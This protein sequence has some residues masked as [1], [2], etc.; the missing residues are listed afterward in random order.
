MDARSGQNSPCP[1]E[2]L[3]SPA[4]PFGGRGQRGQIVIT[5]II[6]PPKAFAFQ[7]QWFLSTYV[8][9]EWSRGLSSFGFHFSSSIGNP[10][11]FRGAACTGWALPQCAERCHAEGV[12]ILPDKPHAAFWEGIWRAKRQLCLTG[13][14]AGIP[15]LSSFT[16]VTRKISSYGIQSNNM[17]VST[18][19]NV[20]PTTVF[21]GLQVADRVVVQAG[22]F[23]G[24]TMGCRKG[25]GKKTLKKE[26]ATLWLESRYSSAV[27]QTP[28][29]TGKALAL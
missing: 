22:R 21:Q 27:P 8:L 16:G 28:T 3:Q 10:P 20:S 5:L 1:W 23:L 24:L 25:K 12:K 29:D 11:W 9:K 14:T 15:Q 13:V 2:L 6:R 17:C 26:K 4:E 18:H 7:T 19:I